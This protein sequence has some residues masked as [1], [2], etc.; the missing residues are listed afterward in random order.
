MVAKTYRSFWVAVDAITVSS[1][2]SGV[3]VTSRPCRERR[4]VGAKLIKCLKTMG[5]VGKRVI[6][7]IWANLTE[8][9]IESGLNDELFKAETKKCVTAEIK[10]FRP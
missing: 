9:K 10:R 2:R 1:L 8:K 4:N 6:N 5:D 7:K 3:C